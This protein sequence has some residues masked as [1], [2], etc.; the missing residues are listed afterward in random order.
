[1]KIK[2]EFQKESAENCMLLP[3]FWQFCFQNLCKGRPL[4]GMVA[5]CMCMRL[6]S[7]VRADKY[8]FR[9]FPPKIPQAVFERLREAC[10]DKALLDECFRLD[11]KVSQCT[12]AAARSGKLGPNVRYVHDRT[13]SW[14][15][16]FT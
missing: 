16:A 9:P 11:T 12:E 2:L 8:G 7:S 6:T 14:F 15:A 13:E 1:M 3:K 10:G 4:L 5:R